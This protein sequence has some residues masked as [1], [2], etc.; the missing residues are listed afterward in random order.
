MSQPAPGLD[1]T[2][3]DT[4]WMRQKHTHIHK[5]HRFTQPLRARHSEQTGSLCKPL[6]MQCEMARVCVSVCGQSWPRSLHSLMKFQGWCWQL[7]ST[8]MCLCDYDT[9]VLRLV[10]SMVKTYHNR[11]KKR[12]KKK[13]RKK[14]LLTNHNNINKKI[15]I[16]YFD[17][18]LNILKCRWQFQINLKKCTKINKIHRK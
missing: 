10:S 2:P 14:R 1:L 5:P 11:Q 7:T 17:Y 8:W 18:H 15:K 4:H 16:K 9:R 3:T 12:K 13:K 6:S